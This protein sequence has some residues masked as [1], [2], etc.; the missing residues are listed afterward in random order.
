MTKVKFTQ[1]QVDI[2]SLCLKVDALDK[3]MSEFIEN[4]E[5]ESK[6]FTDRVNSL[7]KEHLKEKYWYTLRSIETRALY[8]IVASATTFIFYKL[9]I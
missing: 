5:L 3:K 8:I 7:E 1:E 9:L 4:H 6:Q 2:K